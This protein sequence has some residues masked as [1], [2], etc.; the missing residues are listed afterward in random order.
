MTI[1]YNY[2]ECRKSRIMNLQASNDNEKWGEKIPYMSMPDY[3]EFKAIPPF[4]GTVIRYWFRHKKNFSAWCSVYL[5]CYDVLGCY[6]SP[7]FEVYPYED[8][9]F[10]C[11]IDEVD[12][13]TQAIIETID[14]QF[15]DLQLIKKTDETNNT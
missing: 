15:I 6:N 9:V 10:R 14:K 11:K 3:I 1:D 5:D 4:S 2:A 12:L 13:L 7:Y 8:D